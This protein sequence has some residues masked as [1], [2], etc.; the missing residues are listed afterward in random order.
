MGVATS[1]A[2]ITTNADIPSD[3]ELGDS[4]LFVVANGIPSQPFAVTVEPIV[5]F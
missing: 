5:I 4:M 2:V 3:S 1:A